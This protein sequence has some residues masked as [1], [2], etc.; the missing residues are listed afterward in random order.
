MAFRREGTRLTSSVKVRDAWAASWK[1]EP[2]RLPVCPQDF[3]LLFHQSAD[4]VRM[5]PSNFRATRLRY[6]AVPPR[7]LNDSDQGLEA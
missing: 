7:T 3:G 5:L 4:A 6:D 2:T 1:V